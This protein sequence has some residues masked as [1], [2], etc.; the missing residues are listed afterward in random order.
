MIQKQL[1]PL[2]LKL[3]LK[4]IEISRPMVAILLQ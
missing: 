4:D 2:G 1:E 3:D